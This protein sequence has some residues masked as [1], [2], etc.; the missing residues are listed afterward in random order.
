MRILIADDDPVSRR[1]LES[2]LVRLGHEVVSVADGLEAIAA[3]QLPDAPRLAIL[4][5]MMPGADG[6]TVCRTIRQRPDPYIY[7]ILLT[8]RDRREDMVAGLDAEADDFLTKPFNVIELRARLRSGE[9]VVTLQ[10]RLLKTQDRLLKTQEGLLKTQE[11]LRFEA[12]HDRLTGLWN[13]G[14]ILDTLA[15][16][17]NR[18]AR[19][20]QPTAIAMVDIDHFKSVNDTHGHAAGDNVL[21]HVA[22][23]MRTVMRNYDAIGRY[24]GE[25]FL[26]ILP[27][28]TCDTARVS[29][30]R[31]RASVSASPMQI[32]NVE[33]FTSISIGIAC[34]K[35][36]V[37]EASALIQAAD[38][39]LYRAKALGRNRVEE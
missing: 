11:E 38:E 28:T 27:N 34:T 24:G 26:F 7:A 39:A 16:E 31:A 18:A 23:C 10:E 30:E 13:R 22:T 20:N 36:D 6:L 8:A 21:R 29:A 12:T 9:R 33:L 2:T 15:N 1:L 14:M 35:P 19:A 4:D 37:L 25:E 5:W 32:G 3:L 17:L